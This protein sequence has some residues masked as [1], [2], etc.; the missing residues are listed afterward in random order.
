MYS[1]ANGKLITRSQTHPYLPDG[2]VVIDGTKIKEVGTTAELRAKYPE[3]DKEVIYGNMFAVSANTKSLESSM[4]VITLLNTDPDIKN[5]LQYGIEDVNYNL[6]IQTGLLKR[7][8]QSYMM[9]MNKTGNCFISYPEEGL[10]ADYWEDAKAQTNEALI[11]PLMGFDFNTELNVYGQQL[12]DQLLYRYAQMVE[13]YS[14]EIENCATYDELYEYVEKDKTGLK[15]I[16]S[17]N[18]GFTLGNTT[19]YVNFEKL[20]NPKYNT[21]EMDDEDGESPYTV[22]YSWLATYGYLPE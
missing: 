3:A 17:K 6:D 12:D 13:Y 11:D 7:L 10:P 20:T 18:P 4:K 19:V 2:G 1:L 8:N 16:M 22:Y 15:V 5:L 21:N 9:D 14:A